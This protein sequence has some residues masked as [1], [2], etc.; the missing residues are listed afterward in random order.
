MFPTIFV[1][2]S[3]KEAMIK[4]VW[5]PEAVGAVGILLLSD[6]LMNWEME[7]FGDFL[8]CLS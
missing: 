6:H 3:Q 1:V 2:S 4:D 8:L 7:G 5:S